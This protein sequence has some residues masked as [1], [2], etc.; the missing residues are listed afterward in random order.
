MITQP[1]LFRRESWPTTR[2]AYFSSTTAPTT[3]STDASSSDK[4]ATIT[5][6][7]NS[8]NQPR[9]SLSDKF[10][11]SWNRLLEELVQR[12]LG[13]MK[14][15]EWRQ[16]Q[17]LIKGLRTHRALDRSPQAVM[18][19]FGLLDRLADELVALKQNATKNGEYNLASHFPLD[20]RA[21]G[22]VLAAWKRVL[23]S[24]RQGFP[25]TGQ[26]VLQKVE[27]YRQVGLFEPNAITYTVLIDSLRDSVQD[28]GQAT[29][30]AQELLHQ[31]MEASQG[32]SF[33]TEFLPNHTTILN[34]IYAFARSREPAERSDALV[35]NLYQWYEETKRPDLQPTLKL[36]TGLIRAH[37]RAGSSLSQLLKITS[38][39]WEACK[40]GDLE[41]DLIALNGMLHALANTREKAAA[42][43]VAIIF[44]ELFQAYRNGN[45]QC[46]PNQST[47]LAVISALGK[48]GQVDRAESVMQQMEDLYQE[49]LDPSVR[50]NRACYGALVWAHVKSGK[51]SK[52]QAEATM[53]RMSNHCDLD[54][55]S[56]DGVLASWAHSGDEDAAERIA[57]VIQWLE[58]EDNEDTLSSS[59]STTNSS[60]QVTK[61]NSLMGSFARS[62][63]PQQGARL[64]TDLFQWMHEQEDERLHPNANTY[65]SLL[66][67]LQKA[68]NPSQ[69]D[70]ILRLAC[71][72][73]R[74]N[75]KSLRLEA[76]HFNI[77]LS[78]WSESDDMKASQHAKSL[79]SEMEKIGIS[80]DL[81]TYNTLLKLYSKHLHPKRRAE[82][83]VS[84]LREV[85]KL[86]H[87]GR[88]SSGPDIVSYNT[89]MAALSRFGDYKSKE[90]AISLFTE[91]QHR[92]LK[93]DRATYNTLMSIYAKLEEP[94][95]V[96][97][98]FRSMQ[99]PAEAGG[100]D[101]RQDFISYTI[102]L[103]A[104][105]KAGRP[106][107]ALGVLEEMT[108][109]YESGQLD[110]RPSTRDFNAVLQAWLKSG[111]EH[112]PYRCLETLITMQKLAIEKQFDCAPDLVSY[113]IVITALVRLHKGSQALNLLRTMQARGS[114]VQP[115]MTTYTQVLLGLLYSTGGP[116]DAH[117]EVEALLDEMSS[118]KPD[119]WRNRGTSKT[120]QPV[121][122]QLLVSKIEM[123]EHLLLKLT[124]AMRKHGV[125]I[126]SATQLV[127]P[128]NTKK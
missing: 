45:V 30:L 97:K 82:K 19:G 121:C 99:V 55:D 71:Q 63:S 128:Q 81:V 80:P 91:M 12:P 49:I 34:L 18:D 70:S 100:P 16:A 38:E 64:A 109:L 98:V 1:S 110:R 122:R 46:Q 7:D 104:W 24:N 67:A 2:V 28:P 26:Q 15:M 17:E 127:L 10:V 72:E 126:G 65:I 6:N 94:E 106:E 89:V 32:D 47:F 112:A 60:T 13:A 87:E 123:K 54:A 36:H 107:S 84:L 14:S 8:T 62:K 56:W 96:E 125:W 105:A 53:L 86:H 120:L 76:T 23:R 22:A 66:N 21:L 111:S 11:D 59:S 51:S 68:N 73:F 101:L 57:T 85:G 74:A 69:A 5:T 33:D 31:M 9:P 40:R 25:L 79:L 61:Y 83:C 90:Q 115:N 4:V 44:Q 35:R 93:P 92:G 3:K 52:D 29:R 117:V 116:S 48:T 39:A 88:L 75:D 108:D 20:L 37:A 124:D 114:K 41:M 113:N 78:A 119:F 43:A 58:K 77:C 50:P 42:D 95:N 27:N 103:Q 118:K 102:L